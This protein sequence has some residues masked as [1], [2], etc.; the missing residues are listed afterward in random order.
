M[1]RR[2]GTTLPA[3]ALVAIL[4]ACSGDSEEQGQDP[5]APITDGE[6][7]S[8]T[9]EATVKV[10]GDVKA[11]WEAEGLSILQDGTQAFYKTDDGNNSLSV[12]PAIEDQPATA[13]FT[14]KGDSYT[15]QSADGV[16]ADADGAGAE[17]DTVATGV[18]PGS[19]VKIKADIR[20]GE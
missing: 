17:V 4:T 20:C 19:E 1:T 8:E 18:K 9:C 6:E 2:L 12:F 3:L 13:V 15:T 5:T 7:T 16:D 14:R 10:K 11:S